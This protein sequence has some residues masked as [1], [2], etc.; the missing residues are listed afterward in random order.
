ME[1]AEGAGGAEHLV[2]GFVIEGD[3]VQVDGLASESPEP[4]ELRGQVHQLVQLLR[5]AHL[6]GEVR[7]L[8]FLLEGPKEVAGVEPPDLLRDRRDLVLGH[9]EG[10]PGVADSTPS[11]VGV[12]HGDQ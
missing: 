6:R 10:E 1:D 3:P 5:L 12:G 7:E 2:G 8:G 9:A 11:P 4:V